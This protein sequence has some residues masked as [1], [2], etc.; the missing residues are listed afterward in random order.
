MFDRFAGS[1]AK[2]WWKVTANIPP[3]WIERAKAARK[4]REGDVAKAM[5]KLRDLQENR[6]RAAAAIKAAQA[7]LRLL[8]VDWEVSYQKETFYNGLRVLMELSRDGT[9]ER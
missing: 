4:S 8:L 6:P 3:N 2:A 1:P 9:S 5:Q 7:E